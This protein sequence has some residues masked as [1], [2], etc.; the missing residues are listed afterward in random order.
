MKLFISDC[1]GVLIDSEILAARM[2]VEYLATFGVDLALE[3]Y[4]RQWSGMTFSSIMRALAPV[5]GFELP[6]D[7][8]EVLIKKH[9]EYAITN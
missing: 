5:H 3:D 9:E 2:M 7:F 4:L 6:P 8:V 1:D